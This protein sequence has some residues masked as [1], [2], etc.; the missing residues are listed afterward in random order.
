ME[1]LESFLFLI[2]IL[3]YLSTIKANTF[4]LVFGAAIYLFFII[5]LFF[6]DPFEVLSTFI[7]NIFINPLGFFLLLVPLAIHI[8]IKGLKKIWGIKKDFK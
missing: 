4:F 2:I 7:K 6:F 5:Q 1:I 8:L 3:I